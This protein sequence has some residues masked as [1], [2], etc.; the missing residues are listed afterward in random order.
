MSTVKILSILEAA[1]IEPRQARAIAECLELVV[2]E[3]RTA[4]LAH[5][6]APSPSLTAKETCHDF[7]LSL[8][9]SKAKIILWMSILW[10]A[11][12]FATAALIKLLQ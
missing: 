1:S 11:Q 6:P 3:C 12:I 5:D 10:I 7:W 9:K 4:A 2:K 8:S